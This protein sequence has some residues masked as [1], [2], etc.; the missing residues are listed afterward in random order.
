M[1]KSSLCSA[2]AVAG[3]ALCCGCDK[4]VK[5]NN[6]KIELLTR[7]VVQYEQ[8]QDREMAAIRAELTSLGPMLDKMNDSYFEKSHDQAIFFHTNTLYLLLMVDRKIEA[9]LQQADVERATQNAQ[10]YAYYTNQIAQTSLSGAQIQNAL[11]SL[12][13][14]MDET[15]RQAVA[16]LRAELQRQIR[17]VM[18]DA[19][20]IARQKQVAA[21]LAEMKR[22]LGL[23]QAQLAALKPN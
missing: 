3:L 6:A 5:I 11:A 17:L 22:E 19:A 13:S 12:E 8:S 18:P 2:L 16:D 9:H 7:N 15:N 1:N 21:D 4:Q 10:A 23:I 14:R 20:E